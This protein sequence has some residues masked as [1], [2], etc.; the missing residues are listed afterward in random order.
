[1]D[2]EMWWPKLKEGGIMAG[3][4]YLTQFDLSG[5]FP[6]F[7]Y[8]IVIWIKYNK[9]QEIILSRTLVGTTL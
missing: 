6:A 9:W 3:H 7:F 4:D 2:I 8:I 5:L 1:M